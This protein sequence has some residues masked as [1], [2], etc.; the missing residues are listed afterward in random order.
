MAPA[1]TLLLFALLLP[2]AVLAQDKGPDPEPQT[3][4]KTDKDKTGKDKTDKDKTDKDEEQAK[5]DQE[6]A[7]ARKAHAQLIAAF[8]AKK[9]GR[10]DEAERLAKEAIATYPKYE[11]AYL[12]LGNL[13][14]VDIGDIDAAITQFERLIRKTKNKR[15]RATALAE[16]ASAKFIKTRKADPTIELYKAAFNLYQSWEYADKA[17]NLMLHVAKNEQAEGY[18]ERALARI[19]TYIEREE[20]K[21]K[22]GAISQ[23][24]LRNLQS[25]YDMRVK[26]KLQLATCRF[27]MNKP[28][29]G[30]AIL[31][32]MGDV[33]DGFEYNRALVRAAQDKHRAAL[34]ALQI[35]MRTRKTAKAR[36]RLRLF[37][38]EEPLFRKTASLKGFQELVKD[39]PEDEK[40]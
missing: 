17:S 37:I 15:I 27:V 35:F 9:L 16:L 34:S 5:K 11:R 14:M 28:D 20:K 33:P 8:N 1:K 24:G 3:P 36:N 25:L 21:K 32:A 29:Q 40:K 6:R 19:D 10:H 13:Y 12:F 38:R 18:A 7:L 23:A 2:G 4:P 22:S 31:E 39:E 26:V 30:R